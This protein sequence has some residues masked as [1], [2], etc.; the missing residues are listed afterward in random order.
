[1]DVSRR[2]WIQN[3]G[4]ESKKEKEKKKKKTRKISC[5]T[6]VS[7][8]MIRLLELEQLAT[9]FIQPVYDESFEKRKKTRNTGAVLSNSLVVR[10]CSL[11]L[12]VLYTATRSLKKF[13]SPTRVLF[14]WWECLNSVLTLAVGGRIGI[15]CTPDKIEEKKEA[16]RLAH[17]LHH[18]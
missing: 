10:M 17:S 1:M 6:G 18:S 5:W 7:L 15:Y 9:L 8:K 14:I 3:D 2:P 11:F 4:K 12:I 13:P 16:R